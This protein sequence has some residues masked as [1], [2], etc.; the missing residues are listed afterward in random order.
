MIEE[1]IDNYIITNNILITSAPGSG[2][3]SFIQ[4]LVNYIA[5]DDKLIL[6]YNPSGDM[7]RY[8][9]T[10]NYKRFYDNILVI[11][12][13]I[14]QFINFL[15]FNEYKFDYIIIDP[16]DS[17]LDNKLIIS[18][19]SKVL[20]NNHVNYIFSSQIRTN[21]NNSQ[22]YSTL[23]EYNKKN[24]VFKY[25]IWIRNA[26]DPSTEYISKYIDVFET[27]R[28][29]NNY[30]ARYLVKFTLDGKVILI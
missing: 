8:F 24:N 17:L 30:I 19:L 25:S 26:T 4:F 6:Y 9:I 23:E 14:D 7:C 10:D 16:G 18:S 20:N 12:S 28:Q 3:S 1:L 27:A 29:G 15:E 21:P 2:T 13:P 22:T 11:Q 5:S